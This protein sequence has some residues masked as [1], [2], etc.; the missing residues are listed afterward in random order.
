MK[1]F[2]LLFT[3]LFFFVLA[4]EKIKVKKTSYPD[5][6]PKEEWEITQ[7]QYGQEIKDGYYKAWYQNGKLHHE[8]SYMDDKKHGIQKTYFE[9][10][11]MEWEENYLF[12]KLSGKRK[13]WTTEGKLILEVEYVEGKKHGT[14]IRYREDGKI[15]HEIKFK[16]NIKH[17]SHKIYDENG[18]IEQT[19]WFDGGRQV[20]AP[21][22]SSMAAAAPGTAAK[23]DSNAAP[24]AKSTEG[25]ATDTASKKN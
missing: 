25:V 4:C 11:Q 5:G 18:K 12:G 16:H 9:N 13:N 17:G 10:G 2:T 24:P 3:S 6:K 23:M 19:N 7:D 14:H 8:I 1:Q 20:D 22:D 15:H 21:P